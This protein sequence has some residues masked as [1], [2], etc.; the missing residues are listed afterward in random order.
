MQ[1]G[2]HQRAG[3]RQ[4]VLPGMPASG[5]V[6]C[7]ISAYCSLRLQQLSYRVCNLNSIGAQMRGGF[8]ACNCSQLLTRGNAW[9]VVP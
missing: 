2:C 5:V 8:A 1:G 7:Q 4:A 3:S 6:A 9:G